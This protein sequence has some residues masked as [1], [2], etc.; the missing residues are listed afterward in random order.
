MKHPEKPNREKNVA[1]A[2]GEPLASPD[3]TLKT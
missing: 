2:V 1:V 3:V